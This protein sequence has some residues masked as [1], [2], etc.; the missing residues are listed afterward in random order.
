M[1]QNEGSKKNEKLSFI[2]NTSW[3]MAQQIYSMILS[4][5]VGSLSARY[6]GPS[7]YGLLSYG[8]SLI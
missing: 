3:M 5:V 7:N 6:L 8:S 2:S 4:L 1:K